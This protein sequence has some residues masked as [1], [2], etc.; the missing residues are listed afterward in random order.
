MAFLIWVL[1][2]LIVVVVCREEF[3]F[4]SRDTF[5]NS[6]MIKQNAAEY[7]EYLANCEWTELSASASLKGFFYARTLDQYGFHDATPAN[8]SQTLRVR[9]CTIHDKFDKDTVWLI[10]RVGPLHSVGGDMTHFISWEDPGHVGKRLQVEGRLCLNAYVARAIDEAGTPIGYPPIHMH[11]AHLNPDGNP[12]LWAFSFNIKQVIRAALAISYMNPW[13]PLS[14]IEEGGRVIADKRIDQMHGDM[15]CPDDMGGMN[16]TIH[17][18]P[19]SYGICFTRSFFTDAMLQDMR[20]PNSPVLNLWYETALRVS[21][22]AD[23]TLSPLVRYTNA[24]AEACRD[25]FGFLP[26]P[27]VTYRVPMDQF[28][29]MAHTVVLEGRA[30][31]LLVVTN[32]LH[33][34]I[35]LEHW[36]IIGERVTLQALGLHYMRRP[37]GLN[38]ASHP[39]P[40]SPT[41][42]EIKRSILNGVENLRREGL[43]VN[44]CIDSG[45][46]V[47][48]VNASSFQSKL[49]WL[50]GDYDR[51]SGLHCDS[52]SIRV[53]STTAT[54]VLVTQVAFHQPSP[55]F[56]DW[57]PMHAAI[58]VQGSPGEDVPA[59]RPQWIVDA[60]AL[61]YDE[62][63]TAAIKCFIFL[64]LT[65]I[66]LLACC[67][68]VCSRFCARWKKT[69]PYQTVSKS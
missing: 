6:D 30:R 25:K 10:Q 1:T 53:P 38:V 45:P 42:H 66:G 34:K 44:L 39:M 55:D 20:A 9:E 67:I 28:S 14:A 17:R 43:A 59:E 36:V 61:T 22:R 15:Q 49:G 69:T 24:P 12:Y 33:R 51:Y 7:H 5:Y 46:H 11:H 35:A 60:A 29:Y 48:R 18:L 37:E 58:F 3:T 56:K 32:H 65:S 57:F 16:C 41:P 62:V 64:C 31:D 40:G 54:P 50:D 26:D 47:L 68:T 19:N 8:A 63:T 4:N 2:V 27:F 21:K 52:A 13:R 23:V